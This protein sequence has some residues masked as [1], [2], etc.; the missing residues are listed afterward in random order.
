MAYLIWRLV[1]GEQF[2]EVES[3]FFR[4]GLLAVGDSWD[5]W[6]NAL[7]STG[8]SKQ[9]IIYYFLEISIL[10]LAVISCLYTMRHYPESAV[11]GLGVIFISATS[12][13]PQSMSRYMLAVPSI[14]I[15]AGRM[16]KNVVFHNAWLVA[17]TLLMSLL[18]IIFTF[19]F[20]AG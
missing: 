2:H 4:R 8:G 5:A 1:M 12:G 20:W 10:G 18:T 3:S 19:D 17:G 11:F 6:K 15:F 7:T 13:V 9:S 14:F 16:G